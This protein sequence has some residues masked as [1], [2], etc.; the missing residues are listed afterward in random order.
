MARADSR[1]SIPVRT[2]TRHLLEAMK[3]HDETY[4]ELIQHLTE[5]YC[6][7][8]AEAGLRRR[9]ADLQSGRVKGIPFE[10]M[11]RRLER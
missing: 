2:S 4:D 5:E 6:P 1:T 11:R 3:G 10:A 9:V 8:R 7:P